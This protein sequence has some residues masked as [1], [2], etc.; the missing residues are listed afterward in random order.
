MNQKSKNAVSWAFTTLILLLVALVIIVPMVWIVLCAFRPQIEIIKYPPTYYPQTFTLANFLDISKKISTTPITST[1]SAAASHSTF[2]FFI[3]HPFKPVRCFHGA[4]TVPHRFS[5]PYSV[6]FPGFPVQRPA[7]PAAVH[8]QQSCLRQ[9]PPQPELP[10][11]A[12]L[13]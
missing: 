6:Y 11:A 4:P 1:T 5:F 8:G 7:V 13:P 10:A 3:G 2:I 12:G 9:R